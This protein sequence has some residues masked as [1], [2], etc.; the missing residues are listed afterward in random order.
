MPLP[1]VLGALGAK[2]VLGAA[3]T[4]GAV[5]VTKGVK[6]VMDSNEA[7][8][9]I[10]RA[11]RIIDRS[12]K[13]IED[14]KNETAFSLKKLGENKIETCSDEIRE[15]LFYFS[16]IKNITLSDVL[17]QD[18]LKN[19]NFG[20]E[21]LKSMEYVSL[22]ATEILKSGVGGVAAGTLLAWGSYSAIGALGAASTGASIAGLS[23]IAATN[24]TLAWL[25]GG[26][27]AVGGG[28]MA[29]GTAVL[30]GLVAGPALLIAGGIFGAKAEEKLNNAYSNLSEAKVIS[31]KLKIARTE[32][33]NI[34][35]ITLQINEIL[36][37]LRNYLKQ[38]NERLATIVTKS[39]D[40][41]VYTREE[42]E[43]V[44]QALK[45]A[46]GI[47]LIV[48]TPILNEDGS[49]SIQAK[50]MIATPAEESI[51]EKKTETKIK[52]R[53]CSECGFQLKEEAKFCSECGTRA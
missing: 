21:T 37:M 23:G 10:G 9:V 13:E 19:L 17:N 11:E 5:G 40:W 22:N 25:G 12:Q 46:Q 6:G 38:E 36:V 33:E 41:K 15:F 4:A 44:M 31:E 20:N 24:A 18:E 43:S 39:M 35:N 16:K 3:V 2:L 14:Q 29:L 28:G 51:E 27:I 48:D 49:I 32:L 50:K 30:G 52:A 26:S 1:F 42:K 8:D 45:M 53:F 7:D 34:Q 47:K